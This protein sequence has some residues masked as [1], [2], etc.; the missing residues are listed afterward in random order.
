LVTLIAEGGGADELHGPA[1]DA[2]EAGV[3]N[4]GNDADDDADDREADAAAGGLVSSLHAASGTSAK[5]A[6]VTTTDRRNT[7]IG[8]VFHHR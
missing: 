8:A 4:A 3:G 7:A 5:A 6:Q 2:V 1:E